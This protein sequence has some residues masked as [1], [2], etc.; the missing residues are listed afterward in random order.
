[1]FPFSPC[2]CIHTH[3]IAS[4][5]CNVLKGCMHHIFLVN[6]A[7]KGWSWQLPSQWPPLAQ[8]H[9]RALA[10]SSPAPDC[11]S[12]LG[13][14]LPSLSIRGQHPGAWSSGACEVRQI[15]W[16]VSHVLRL[17]LSSSHGVA[18]SAHTYPPPPPSPHPRDWLTSPPPFSP[19]WGFVSCT[20]TGL[21]FLNLCFPQV[22]PLTSNSAPWAG[23]VS[24][25]V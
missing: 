15:W 22:P 12:P 8:S 6:S 9:A 10:L 13:F 14:S 23:T 4:S 11:A 20:S 24:L 5:C 21:K 18:E 2:S 3:F 25:S 17:P 16:I 7:S 19:L 1:M